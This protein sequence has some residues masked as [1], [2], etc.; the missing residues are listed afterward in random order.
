MK[1]KA[2]SFTLILEISLPDL[3]YP[4][5]IKSFV[6]LP[7]LTL[8]NSIA[9]S[10]ILNARWAQI[11]V[12]VAVNPNKILKAIVSFVKVFNECRK[13][14]FGKYFKRIASFIAANYMVTIFILH[15]GILRCVQ[16]KGILVMSAFAE[17]K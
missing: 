7:I 3:D 12:A 11:A 8:P 2:I 5:S 10:A 4:E 17:C 9:S 14:A 13:S 15:I 1:S 16:R 6:C